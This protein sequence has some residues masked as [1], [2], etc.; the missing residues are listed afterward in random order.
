MAYLLQH[1]LTDSAARTP[2]RPA[3]AV[4]E[5]RLSAAAGFEIRAG[6]LDPAIGQSDLGAVA[7][8]PNAGHPRLGFEPVNGGEHGG[9]VGGVH[10][11]R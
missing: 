11:V 1:L 5:R 3:V 6:R 4:G 7:V 9:R 8:A 2:E 10:R